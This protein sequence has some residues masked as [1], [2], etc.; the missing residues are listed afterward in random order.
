[1]KKKKEPDFPEL[2]IGMCCLCGDY[3]DKSRTTML[4]GLEV[5]P[6]CLEALRGG[7]LYLPAM[8]GLCCGLRAGEVCGLRWSDV[9]LDAGSLVIRH[10]VDSSV[11]GKPVLKSTKTGRLAKI[12]LPEEVKNELRLAHIARCG[13]WVVCEDAK[14]VQIATARRRAKGQ[15]VEVSPG[16]SSLILSFCPGGSRSGPGSWASV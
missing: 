13:E 8:L 11:P 5:C 10:S 1:M 4:N 12:G 16:G 6:D 9:D 3:T 14:C 2:R 7:W 15:D